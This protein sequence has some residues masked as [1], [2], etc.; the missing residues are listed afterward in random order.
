MNTSQRTPLSSPDRIGAGGPHRGITGLVLVALLMA[1]QSCAGQSPELTCTVHVPDS[2]AVGAAV[3]LSLGLG[4]SGST[5]LRVLAWGT[6]FEEAWLQP[7]VEVSRDGAPLVYGGAT[8]KRGDPGRD[9]YVMVG[10]G[11]VRTA[12]LDLALVFPI[13]R[14][15]RYRVVPRITL[16]DLVGEGVAVPRPREAHAPLGLACAPVEFVVTPAP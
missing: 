4:N 11:A 7:F 6:P 8:V 2:V 14:P 12:T 16:H 10:A 13:D 9:E 5:G 1:S 3:P 15:G